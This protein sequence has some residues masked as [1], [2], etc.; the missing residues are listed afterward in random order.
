MVMARGPS[1]HRP[2]FHVLVLAAGF[3]C[4]GLLTQVARRFLPAG[5]VKESWQG[6]DGL[7]RRRILVG[8]AVLGAFFAGRSWW[9][10][11]RSQ[12]AADEQAART[13]KKVADDQAAREAKAAAEAKA[14]AEAEERRKTAE[15][16][17]WMEESRRRTSWPV[18]L[19]VLLAAL[20]AYIRTLGGT[21]GLAQDF[22]GPMA[23]PH[24]MWLMAAACLLAPL[25]TLASGTHWTLPVALALIAAGALATCGT[26]L[27]AIARCLRE[28]A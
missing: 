8:A 12:L 13:K 5:A 21:L 15:Q 4:G 25:E 28:A 14:R 22:R 6:M 26:R 20:T 18:T 27:H 1:K 10:G 24:R 9:R 7:T 11:R 2:M 19:V 3:V 17:A 16:E 23:K